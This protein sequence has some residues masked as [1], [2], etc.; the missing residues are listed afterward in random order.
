MAR[1]SCASTLVLPP[2]R[3]GEGWG[4][5]PLDPL[6]LKAPPPNLPLPSQGEGLKSPKPT[7]QSPRCENIV[8]AILTAD[9]LPVLFAAADG[10]EVAAAHAGWRGLAAGVLERTVAAMQTSPDRLIAWLGPAAGPQAY[11]VGAEVFEAFV[12]GDPRAAFRVRGD[13]ARPLACR[14][15]RLGASAS[16]RCGR[17]PRQRRRPVHHL[18]RRPLLFAP[19]RPA[20]RPNGDAGVSGRLRR[21]QAGTRHIAGMSASGKTICPDC[22]LNAILTCYGRGRGAS[23]NFPERHRHDPACR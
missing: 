9:C 15:L 6:I 21:H 8:L 11:E 23:P 16:G 14:S 10:S 5:V 3:A 13:A 17:A 12:S 19:P 18:R 22:R 1:R 20:Q 2:L 7:P 4:G